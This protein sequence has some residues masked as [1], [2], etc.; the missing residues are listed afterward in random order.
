MNVERV[1]AGIARA[2]QKG[3]RTGRAIGR[4]TAAPRKI[5]AAQRALMGG[6]TVRAAA[7]LSG[8]SVGKVAGLRKGMEAAAN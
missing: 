3:T 7:E 4:P 1:N 5:E 8:L 6:A 2:R